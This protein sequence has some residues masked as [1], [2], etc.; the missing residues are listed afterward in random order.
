MADNQ[1]TQALRRISIG[2]CALGVA[3]LVASVALFIL[4]CWAHGDTPARFFGTGVILF[5]VGVALTAFG[6][7]GATDD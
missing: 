4:A 7:L 5:V 6:A 3:A 1:V 2:V